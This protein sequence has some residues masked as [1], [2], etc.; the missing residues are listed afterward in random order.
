M[1]YTDTRTPSASS[2]VHHEMLPIMVTLSQQM[3]RAW[4]NL[5]RYYPGKRGNKSK[6]YYET[7]RLQARRRR[8][9]EGV[10]RSGRGGGSARESH[11]VEM[12]LS[13][14]DRGR[15]AW[16]RGFLAVTCPPGV[17]LAHQGSEKMWAEGESEG[18]QTLGI[19]V[20]VCS[21]LKLLH[22]L[23]LIDL[24]D[25]KRTL[26]LPRLVCMSFSSGVVKMV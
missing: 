12:S 19:V 24:S 14:E 3:F 26:E 6:G 10:G 23:G 20:V 25:G 5:W 8:A 2:G 17:L 21:S 16:Q 18:L 15:E 22:Y 13:W 4:L 11:W 9:V 1:V 7:W